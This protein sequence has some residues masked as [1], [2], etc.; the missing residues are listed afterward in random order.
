[1]ETES[2]DRGTFVAVDA[3]ALEAAI[4][5]LA[6]YERRRETQ[7]REVLELV[8][9]AKNLHADAK[10]RLRERGASE[11]Q[12]ARYERG[13]LKRVERVRYSMREAELAVRTLRSSL[14]RLR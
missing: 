10:A 4:E 5:E 7:R 9:H 1:M 8:E 12:I 3:A 2:D 14:E 13:Y 11:A 6:E